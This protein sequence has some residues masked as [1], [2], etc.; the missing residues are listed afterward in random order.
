MKDEYKVDL[1]IPNDRKSRE[2]DLMRLMHQRWAYAGAT[3][4]TLTEL[5]ELTGWDSEYAYGAM[6]TCARGRYSDGTYIHEPWM[7][8][9][10]LNPQEKTLDWRPAYATVTRQ[11]LFELYRSEQR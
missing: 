6:E 2:A 8:N 9:C 5:C 10:Q 3:T 7:R 11:G 4:I 1:R